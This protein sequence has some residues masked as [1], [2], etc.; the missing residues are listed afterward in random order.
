MLAVGCSGAYAD[1]QGHVYVGAGIGQASLDGRVRGTLIPTTARIDD[2]DTMWAATVGYEANRWFALEL[3]Y[4]DLGE[5]AAE[6]DGVNL[7]LLGGPIG[8][9][10]V[11]FASTS[12][13]AAAVSASADGLSL[14]GLLRYEFASRFNVYGRAGMSVMWLESKERA[15]T[16]LCRS[17]VGG[18]FVSPD[19]STLPGFERVRAG[20][21]FSSDSTE[22]RFM[23][24][25]GLSARIWD[26]VIA[27]FDYIEYDLDALDAFTVSGSL[28]YRF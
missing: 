28:L 25:V 3:S 12:E 2:E 20:R 19:C 4:V 8:A 21:T 16:D 7:G 22:Y 10:P 17:P 11:P 5:A 24:G 27:R 14:S 6:I 23:Y 1:N 15:L 9:S 26:R 13:P 18:F